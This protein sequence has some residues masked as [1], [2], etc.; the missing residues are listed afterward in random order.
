[1]FNVV[2]TFDTHAKVPAHFAAVDRSAKENGKI[3]II[4]VG[5]DPDFFLSLGFMG[6]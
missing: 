4:S 6:M 3:A 1:M 2:D 5:W